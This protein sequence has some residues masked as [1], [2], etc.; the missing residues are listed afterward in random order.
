MRSD[1]S[2][3]LLF[4]FFFFFW[5]GVGLLKYKT[6][7]RRTQ[8]HVPFANNFIIAKCIIGSLHF[9]F[10]I[11]FFKVCTQNIKSASDQRSHRVGQCTS[12]QKSAG[13][14]GMYDTG[15]ELIVT[16]TCAFVAN[17][18]QKCDA[19]GLQSCTERRNMSGRQRTET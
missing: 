6:E 18:T 12:D 2:H 7:T 8:V 13:G 9:F 16:K 19:M 11:F 4:F 3:Q 14:G 17:V 10:I 15:T 1:S 5:A